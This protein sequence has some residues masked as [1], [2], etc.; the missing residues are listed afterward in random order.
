M[1]SRAATLERI[2]QV[3]AERRLKKRFPGARKLTSPYEVGEMSMEQEELQLDYIQ[4]EIETHEGRLQELQL[5][6]EIHATMYEDR[7]NA[8]KMEKDYEKHQADVKESILHE[9]LNPHPEPGPP[10][11]GPKSLWWIEG[12]R[13]LVMSS[14]IICFNLYTMM[15]EFSDPKKAVKFFWPDQIFMCFYVFELTIKAFVRQR[16]LL[17]GPCSIVWWNWLDLVIVVS[18]VFDMWLIPLMGA[19]NKSPVDPRA[20][21]ILRLARLA[22]LAR[23][24]K[25]F[26]AADFGWTEHENFQ[27]FIMGVIGCNAIIMG[28]ETD[29]PDFWG[30]FYVEQIL[31]MIFMFEL[32]ARLKMWGFGFFTNGANLIWNWLD[33]IIVGGGMVDAYLIPMYA[34]VQV[35]MG[36]SS[37]D[38]PDIGQV[39]MML[40]LARLLRILRLARLIKSIPPLYVLIQGIAKAM[41]GMVWVVVLTALLLY[42]CALLGVKLVGHGLVFGGKE[43]VPGDMAEVFPDVLNSMFVLFNLMNGSTGSVEPLLK[44]PIMKF[45]IMIYTIISTWAILSILTAVVSGNMIKAQEEN[46]VEEEEN[47]K[48]VQH[49]RSVKVLTYLFE[50]ADKEHDSCLRESEFEGIVGDNLKSAMLIDACGINKEDLKELFEC[51]ATNPGGSAEP[52]VSQVDF[53]DGLQMEGRA[54]SERSVMRLEKHLT[55]MAHK[56]RNIQAEVDFS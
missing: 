39:M 26:L 42:I 54:V 33:F 19:G 46:K 2:N 27:S 34:L 45:F 14:L 4:S 44:L 6:Y 3:D 23:V 5:E 47:S 48:N 43:H 8:Y 13:M 1:T 51:L 11:I 35:L 49:T 7:I 29:I 20:L 12:D 38:K 15:L 10:P 55:D 9:L 25:A 30:W 40:R 50:N 22:R 36:G 18:G 21:R 17:C 41:Q 24:V 52:F 31:L 56:L 53:I 28:L 16:A 37:S 32:S